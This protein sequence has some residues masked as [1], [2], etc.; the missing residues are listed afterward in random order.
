MRVLFIIAGLL[1]AALVVAAAVALVGYRQAFPNP[2]SEIVQLTPEKRVAIGR[3]RAETKFGPHDFPPLGYTGAATSE[4]GAIATAAIDEMLDGVLA[5]PNGPLEAE[6]VIPLVGTAMRKVGRLE[7]ED[8][9]R[10]ADYVVEAWYLLGFK[11]ATGRFAHG[12]AYPRPPGY[13][14]PLPPGWNSP[15]EPRPMG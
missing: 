14:E 7:T 15:T 5:K 1:A 9:D 2:S 10:A 8:R 3:L 12:A 4:D 11:G 6:A 13:L